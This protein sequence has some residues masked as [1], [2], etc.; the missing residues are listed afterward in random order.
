MNSILGPFLMKP[1]S[2]S[3]GFWISGDFT[4]KKLSVAVFKDDKQIQ[5][6]IFTALPESKYG[7][8]LVETEKSLE[9][10]TQ[11]R[12]EIRL[13]GKTE[14][15]GL[16]ASDFT[17]KTFPEEENVTAKY[18]LVSCN[19]IE[20]F[21]RHKGKDESAWTMWER[22]A[23]LSSEESDLLFVISG[24]DQVYMDDTFSVGWKFRFMPESK[25]RSKIQSTYMKYW[26]DISY[27]KVMARL[28]TFLMW[29]DHDLIDGFGSRPEQFKKTSK[30]EEKKLW[31]RYR[32]FLTEAFYEFQACRNPGEVSRMGPFS[33]SFQLMKKG[34]VLL[35]LRSDR[36]APKKELLN[37]NHKALVEAKV[38]SLIKKGIDTLYFVSPVTIARMGGK[39]ESIIGTGANYLW[40]LGDNIGGSSPLRRSI[41]WM[42]LSAIALLSAQMKLWGE[43]GHVAG[44]FIFL[45]SGLNLVFDIFNSK[46]YL[47]QWLTWL[48]RFI[49]ISAMAWIWKANGDVLFSSTIYAGIHLNFF[50]TLFY[51]KGPIVWLAMTVLCANFV[52]WVSSKK[53]FRKIFMGGSF[54]FFIFYLVSFF[55]LGLPGRSASFSAWMVPMLFTHLLGLLFAHLS[56]LEGLGAI[57]AIA[58][59][60]DDVKDSWSS[61][62]NRKELI[63]FYD[64]IEQVQKKGI[65]VVIL[66]GDIHTGGVSKISCDK[67]FGALEETVFQ[68]VSSPVSYVPM[69]PLVE[70]LT[71]SDFVNEL[72]LDGKNLYSY[73]LFYRCKRNFVIVQPSMFDSSVEVEFFFED[74][75]T[76]ER[77]NIPS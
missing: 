1:T 76:P 42:I 54:L 74:L 28:P 6:K 72:G 49:N 13:D 50:K 31:T 22:L 46:N 40:K 23:K 75:S 53:I 17:F 47:P 5:E 44:L 68:I 2:R 48:I 58:G 18:A 15:L 32:T 21:E 63:W 36:N 24:G 73:N 38:D 20:E 64:L 45:F 66:S 30:D 41:F 71:S 14:L 51:L 27:R 19:G 37:P 7:V 59:L 55:W 26:G 56:L 77:V 11:Y 35:D 9:P 52:R 8:Y 4:G 12:Y 10:Y 16:S 33:A 3:M 61:D 69:A 60:D 65:K 39:I 67:T 34:F 25:I 70:K 62:T 43:A 29:D 57:D